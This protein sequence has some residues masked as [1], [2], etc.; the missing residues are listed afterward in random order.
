MNFI[1]PNDNLTSITNKS[2]VKLP[3]NTVTLNQA[4]NLENQRYTIFNAQQNMNA[5]NNFPNVNIK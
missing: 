5:N 2:T 1:N 4:T 3:G